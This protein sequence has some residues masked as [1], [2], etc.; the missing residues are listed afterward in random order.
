VQTPSDIRVALVWLD[1]S[2]TPGTHFS[3]AQE[4]EVHA[5]FPVNFT[6]DITTLPPKAIMGHNVDPSKPAAAGGVTGYALGT[7]VVY[8]DTNGNGKL[9]LLPEDAQTSADRVLGV[10]EGLEITYLE[11]GGI[12]K[13]PNAPSTDEDSVALAAG[14]NLVFEPK[15]ADPEPGCGTGLGSLRGGTPCTR[16]LTTGWT[17]VPSDNTLSIA[18][19]ATPELAR[20]ICGATGGDSA[21]DDSACSPCLGDACA[22]CPLSPTARV[23]CNADKT[24]FI[25]W[26]C[27]SPTVCADKTCQYVS[28]RRDAAA[29]VPAS[30]PCH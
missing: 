18:L 2:G 13:N 28:G 6:L 21:V 7:L 4:L 24:A 11:G 25:A 16:A 5:T 3:V 27:S 26:T 17:V 1:L 20:A 10:P 23:T 19:T 8:E 30:W 22:S 29:A 14:Y 9:D 15:Y 12:P